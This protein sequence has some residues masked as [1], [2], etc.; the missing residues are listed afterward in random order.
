MSKLFGAG[1]TIA[2]GTFSSGFAATQVTEPKTNNDDITEQSMFESLSEDTMLEAVSKTAL[3][4]QRADAAAAVLAWVESGDSESDELDALAFGLAGGSD[5]EDLT[6][7][8]VETYTDIKIQMADFA[9]QCGAKEK[10]CQAMVD[11]DDEAA[12]RVFNA[13]E[14]AVSDSDDDELISN[15]AHREAL[16]LES[17]KKVIR[18]GKV[19]M[20]NKKKRKRRMTSAQKQAL[21]KAQRK[22]HSSSAKAAR[23]KSNRIRKS[24]GMQ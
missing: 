7:D 20:V 5:D 3:I 11:G 17:K 16:I 15:F 6:D 13:V 12:E 23:K 8:Q 19:V 18:D 4:N 22:A 2:S 21:K 24:R 14:S 1:T 10:D 9:M